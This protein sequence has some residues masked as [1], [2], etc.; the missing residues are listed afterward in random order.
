MQNGLHESAE[1]LCSL[2]ISSCF[3]SGDKSRNLMAQNQHVFLELMADAIFAQANYKR[4]LSHFKQAQSSM[5]SV[6]FDVNRDGSVS[7][8]EARLIYKQ[9]LCEIELK[10][11]NGAL[12]LLEQIPPKLRSVKAS[13]VLG[14]LYVEFG[15]RKHAVSCYYQILDIFPTSVEAIEGLILLDIESSIIIDYVTKASEKS[16]ITQGFLQKW[17]TTLIISLEHKYRWRRQGSLLL[18]QLFS[19]IILYSCIEGI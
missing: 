9:A 4:A 7:R 12:K 19:F 16:N 17:L 15:L 13:V 18:S 2:F 1:V 5:A 14:K 11:S 3:P 8:D 10:D 6:N